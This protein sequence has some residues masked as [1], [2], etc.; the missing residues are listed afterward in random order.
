MPVRKSRFLPWAGLLLFLCACSGPHYFDL[1]TEVPES[2]GHGQIGKTLRV[3]GVGINQTYLDSRIVSRESPFRVKYAAYAAWSK[4]PEELIQDAVVRFWKQ[5]AFFSRIAT[6]EDA[7]E[8][9]WTMKI[10][11]EAIEKIRVARKWHAR[12]ALD[13]EIV[14]SRNDDVLLSHSFDRKMSLEGK[15]NRL[16]PGRISWILHDELLKIETRL[17]AQQG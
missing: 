4:N 3:E 9:D 13:I 11:V 8:P 5:R 16:L 12:L 17:L 15:K 6:Y 1:Q 7:V 2:R 10:R 14:D